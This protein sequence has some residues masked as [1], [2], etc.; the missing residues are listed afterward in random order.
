[1][2][3]GLI[4]LLK[5]MLAHLLTD[6]MLQPTAWVTDRANSHFRSFF[7]YIHGFITAAVSLILIG[8]QFWPFAIIIGVTH[9]L[10]DGWKSYRPPS[11][12]YFLVDQ[13]LHVLVIGACF[14]YLFLKWNDSLAAWDKLSSNLYF[15]KLLVA[16]VFLTAPAGFLVGLLTRRWRDAM[17]EKGES[18]ANAGKWIGIIER[19]IVLMLMLYDQYEA[20][21]LLVA[22][23]SILRFNEKERPES[24]TEYLVIGTLISIGLAMLTGIILKQ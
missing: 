9:I 21:G 11:L 12:V 3:A 14:A 23:K 2:D 20:I 15:W 22:A 24:K 17:G 7:L 13:F 8:W 1:M 19:I 6:F 4:F 16:V 10:I 5:L 18:L